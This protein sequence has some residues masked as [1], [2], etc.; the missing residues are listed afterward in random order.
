MEV[1]GFNNKELNEAF[2]V[3]P[4]IVT[5]YI[6]A[7]FRVLKMSRETNAKAIIKIRELTKTIESISSSE[8]KTIVDLQTA[9]EELKS[10]MKE[11]G[12]G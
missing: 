7:T 9:N 5:D 8:R 1:K 11:R 3:S 4:K 6:A 12:E 10:E 2:R